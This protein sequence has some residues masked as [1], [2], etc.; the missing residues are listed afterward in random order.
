MSSPYSNLTFLAGPEALTTVVN[1]DGL[2]PD[3]IEAMP[4]AAGGP[5]WLILNRFDQVIFG[6]WFKDRKTPVDL[7]GSS[8]GAWRFMA[9]AQADPLAALAR[10]E[11]IYSGYCI[12]GEPTPRRIRDDAVEMIDFI[13]GENGAAEILNNPT[14]RLHVM[15][16]RSTAFTSG[17]GKLGL[18]LPSAVAALANAVSRKSLN[19]FFRRALF[20]D[21]R[22]KTPFSWV[23]D[24]PITRIPLTENNLKPAV[25][26][27]G[28]IPIITEGARNIPDAP[29][30]VYRDG[31]VSDYHF[32]MPLLASKSD[33]L[34]FYP[35]YI[36]RIIPGWLDK[37]LKWRKV[38][39]QTLNRMILLTPSKEFVANL[40]GGRIPERQD[41]INMEDGDRVRWWRR[42]LSETD[43]LGDELRDVIAKNAWAE[44]L[45]PFP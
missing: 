30:G 26:A 18:G 17:E 14:I 36:D 41:F 13:M 7:I 32:D 33:G 35:H 8:S 15:T 2:R 10:L 21:P 38:S 28:S 29:P 11:E 27:S 6:E 4:G 12:S 22:V 20:S 31:G 3:Q 44:V 25:V 43:R 19:L 45:K 40:P 34:V 39:P 9:A 37:A 23:N 42:I 5:K 24:L 1:N 16:V